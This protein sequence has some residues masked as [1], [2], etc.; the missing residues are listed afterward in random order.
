[1][2]WHIT[3]RIRYS[4]QSVLIVNIHPVFARLLTRQ[5]N[6]NLWISDVHLSVK[7]LVSFVFVMFEI[8]TTLAIVN[9]Y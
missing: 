3:V 4:K 8:N 7:N 1:M 6:S 5:T 9:L 2:H